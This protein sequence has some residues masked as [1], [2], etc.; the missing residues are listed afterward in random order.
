MPAPHRRLAR[1]VRRPV[2]AVQAF[3]A[4]EAAGGLLLL[5]ATAVALA[6]A[7]VPGIGGY[8][9]YGEPNAPFRLAAQQRVRQAQTPGRDL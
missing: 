7:N 2:L 9:R 8:D 5:G 6:W 4:V 3:L 1:A